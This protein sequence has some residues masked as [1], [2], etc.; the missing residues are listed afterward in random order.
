MSIGQFYSAKLVALFISVDKE[1]FYLRVNQYHK[2]MQVN[3]STRPYTRLSQYRAV[4]QGQQKVSTC[5]EKEEYMF[6]TL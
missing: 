1:D 3:L 4:A 6:S 2:V 5:L